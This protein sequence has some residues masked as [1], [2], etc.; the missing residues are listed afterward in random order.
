M[1][2]R[3]GSLEERMDAWTVLHP[4]APGMR[5]ALAGPLLLWRLGLGRLVSRRA[6]RG[7]RL[8]ALTVTG[9]TTGAPRHL[10]VAVHEI[11]GRTY[12]WCP[13][14][15]R[16]R[17]FRN[18]E[19]NPVVTVQSHTGRRTLRAVPLSDLDEV[20]EVVA[21]L[22]QFDAV[23]LRS[24][25]DSEGVPDTDEGIAANADRLHLRR[26]EPTAEPGPPG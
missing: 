6:I 1:S 7:G 11:G 16:A 12:L 5:E 25:L 21:D 13:Y 2:E 19:A 15:R 3:L 24:Y 9:R 4:H 18:L 26:L 10:P 20:H 14:G 22:R 23:F 8:V 17:W